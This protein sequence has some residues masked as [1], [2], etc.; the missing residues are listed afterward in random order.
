MSYKMRREG[1]NGGYDEFDDA[2]ERMGFIVTGMRE[3]FAF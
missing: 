1:I 3:V 2:E